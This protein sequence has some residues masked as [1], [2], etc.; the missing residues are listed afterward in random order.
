[1]GTEICMIMVVLLL[2]DAICIF[3]LRRNL[4]KLYMKKENGRVQLTEIKKWKELYYTRPMCY[5][6]R[7]KYVENNEKKRKT[8][9]TSSVFLKKYKNKEYIQIVTI[10]GTDFVFLKEEEWKVQNM[11]LS[12]VIVIISAFVLL[13]LFMVYIDRAFISKICGILFLSLPFFIFQLWHETCKTTLNKHKTRMKY[14]TRLTCEEVI[15]N[16]RQDINSGFNLEKENESIKDKIYIFSMKNNVLSYFGCMHHEA[17]YRLLVTQ[18]QEGSAVWLYLYGCTNPYK[19][20]RYAAKLKRFME[21][22]IGA[23]R[24]E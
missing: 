2:S 6:V 4:Y 5:E 16:L 1:M 21:I 8:I 12:I 9:T 23:V 24:V 20:N 11:E 22:S 3:L 10:P 15:E 14:T 18:A 7:I 17:Q 19:L 13:L